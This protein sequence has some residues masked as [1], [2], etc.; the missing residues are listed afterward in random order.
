MVIAGVDVAITLVAYHVGEGQVTAIAAKEIPGITDAT[1]L[2]GQRWQ[3]GI[4][5]CSK[6]VWEGP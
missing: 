5:P 4:E 3:C 1:Q 6:S 2:H